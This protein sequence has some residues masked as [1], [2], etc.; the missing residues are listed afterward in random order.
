[1]KEENLYYFTIIGYALKIIRHNKK[2]VGKS[3][4]E[5]NSIK[6]GDY[7][8]FIAQMKCDAPWSLLFMP[9]TGNI[10]NPTY[11]MCHILLIGL[12]NIGP[13][14]Q[15]FNN[16]LFLEYGDIIDT[17]ITDNI[18]G[19]C[20]MFEI[21]LRDY[22]IKTCPDILLLKNKDR[23]LNT[24]INDYLSST[25]LTPNEILILNSGR[26][27]LNNIKH[28]QDKIKDYTPEEWEI[29]NEKFLESYD[30]IIKLNQYF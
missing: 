7:D 22:A 20:A 25:G 30:L 16:E 4:T 1:M 21:L 19:K 12:I 29:E 14:L 10:E 27:Y 23:T 15:K 3:Q 5:L 17:N 18:Y 26:K 6:H 2:L 28:K 11:D 9:D 13:A 24:I 8:T